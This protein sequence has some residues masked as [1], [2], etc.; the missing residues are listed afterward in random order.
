MSDNNSTKDIIIETFQNHPTLN[1][2][3]IA[4]LVSC[5]RSYAHEVIKE[6]KDIREGKIGL[7]RL[8]ELRIIANAYLTSGNNVVNAARFLKITETKFQKELD[9]ATQFGLVFSELGCADTCV[10]RNRLKKQVQSLQK[11]IL[12]LKKLEVTSQ[13][14]RKHLFELKE[15]DPLPPDWIIQTSKGSGVVGV[16]T[17]QISDIHFGEVVKPEQ[18]YQMNEYSIEIA[19]QRIFNLLRNT[20]DVLFNHLVKSEFPGIVICLNGDLISGNIH[21]ELLATNDFPVMPAFVELYG[22]MITFMKEMA[23]HFKRVLVI[24]NAGGN[25][26]R[27]T[28]K[29]I[30]KDR[31]YSNFDWLLNCLLAKQFED[32]DRINFNISNGFSNQFQIYDHKYRMEHGDAFRGGQGFIGPYAPITRGEIKKRSAAA[33]YNRSYDTL[34][35]GHFHQLMFL[36]KVIVNGSVVG[37]NEYAVGLDFPYEPPKQAL[38]VTHPKRGITLQMPVFCEEKPS[39][40]VDSEWVSWKSQGRVGHSSLK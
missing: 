27:N 6:I 20:I 15:I 5:S 12:N 26:A 37:F 33:S 34:I 35:I 16:P 1:P 9:Q 21:D 8:N 11:E 29:I 32:D 25:H 30:F 23:D 14:I 40:V 31:A 24:G 4:K 36:N 10:E 3:Q 2:D 18:V 7:D 39:S 17:L 28:K 38:W 22:I 19:K 13:E